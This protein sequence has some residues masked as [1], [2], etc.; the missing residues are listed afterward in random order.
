MFLMLYLKKSVYMWCSLAFYC[1]L[2]QPFNRYL[3]KALC[4][5]IE[6]HFNNSFCWRHN[7]ELWSETQHET[8]IYEFAHFD[9]REHFSWELH[10]HWFQPEQQKFYMKLQFLEIS[11]VTKLHSKQ[12]RHL[13]EIVFMQRFPRRFFLILPRNI[14]PSR[15]HSIR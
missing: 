10:G 14:S 8:V 2:L 15:Y 7:R 4:K 12:Y 1:H 11:H 3:F 9:Y 5:W 6:T 13:F